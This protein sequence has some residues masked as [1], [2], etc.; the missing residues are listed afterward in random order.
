MSPAGVQSRAPNPQTLLD[1]SQQ[2]ARRG[3]VMA[4]DFFTQAQFALAAYADFVAGRA[5]EAALAYAGMTKAQSAQFAAAWRVVEQYTDAVTG[6][7][8]TLFQ[9]VSGGPKYLAV[10]G[11]LAPADYFPDDPLTHDGALDQLRSQ[12]QRLKS[13]VQAWLARGTLSAG[14]TVAGHSLGGY[15]A[16][17]LLADL[18]ANISRAYLYNARGNSHVIERIVRSL[19]VAAT[20]DVSKIIRY[21]R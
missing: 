8:A 19:G 14:F 7:S 9:A 16:A 12:Y 6:G 18:G 11:S 10:R 13:R 1:I 3:E 21:P 5:D 20:P 17:G 2:H 15:L 4:D